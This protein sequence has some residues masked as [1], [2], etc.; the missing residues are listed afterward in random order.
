MDMTK[1][2]SCFLSQDRQ[3]ERGGMGNGERITD[4]GGQYDSS[5]WPLMMAAIAV[6]AFT[7]SVITEVKPKEIGFWEGYPRP[8][9]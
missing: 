8:C 4:L 9:R 5:S 7:V 1:V 3:N 6:A 2:M